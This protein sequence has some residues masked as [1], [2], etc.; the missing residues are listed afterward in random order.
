[1]LVGTGG[2]LGIGEKDVALNFNDLRFTQDQD[3]KV[4][5]IANVTKETLASA[6]D[7]Q[8]LA[9]QKVTVGENK[10]DREDKAE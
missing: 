9:E 8:T 10:G 1:M 7:Y 3:G 2:F 6:P 5:V 4:K